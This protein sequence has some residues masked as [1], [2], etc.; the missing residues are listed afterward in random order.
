MDSRDRVLE[1]LGGNVQD[2][3][4][5]AIFTQSAT[6]GQMEAVGVSWP[7]AHSDAGM[8]AALGCAQ[9][10]LFG[11]ESVRVPFDINAEAVRLG[12]ADDAGTVDSQPS[13]RTRALEGDPFGGDLPEF[14]GPEEDGYVADRMAVICDAV[15]ICS[16]RMDEKVAVCAGML[17]PMGLLGQLIGFETLAMTTLVQPDWVERCNERLA[18]LQSVYAKALRDAGADILTLIGDSG[19]MDS[20]SYWRISGRFISEVVPSGTISILHECGDCSSNID[21]LPST[22]VDAILPDQTMDPSL[23]MEKTDGRIGAVGSVDPVGA[24]LQGTPEKVVSEAR[25]YDDAGY[26]VV[27]PGCGVPPRTPNENLAALAHA[28][29]ARGPVCES[30]TSSLNL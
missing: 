14:I 24:L 30:R 16:K 5:V 17:T 21:I 3:P 26:C 10:E 28:F 20:D 2:V 9:A 11:F 29:D 15:S 6:V 19:M 22:G 1:A 23:I 12:C 25:K 7:K 13:I 8:M 27:S 18:R 4:P